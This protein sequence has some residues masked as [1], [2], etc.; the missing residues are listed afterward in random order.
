MA[1]IRYDDII[2]ALATHDGCTNAALRRRLAATAFATTVAYD[3]AIAD[4]FAAQLPV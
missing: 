1:I 2:T 4:Y 3:T